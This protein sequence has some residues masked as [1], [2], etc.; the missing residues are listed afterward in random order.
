MM[1]NYGKIKKY[2]NEN[3]IKEID[4]L[5]FK[6]KLIEIRY[7][8]E[9]TDEFYDHG[10]YG[11]FTFLYRSN[12]KMIFYIKEKSDNKFDIFV[13]LIPWSNFYY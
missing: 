7:S 2:L 3:L 11:I 1:T 10:C 5:Q 12:K 6:D 8:Y 4:N 9:Y 13:R